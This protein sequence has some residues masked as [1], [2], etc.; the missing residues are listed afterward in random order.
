MQV[1]GAGG[2]GVTGSLLRAVCHEALV[3]RM[4]VRDL[5]RLAVVAAGRSWRQSSL[6]I[7]GVGGSSLDKVG[8]AQDYRMGRAR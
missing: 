8:S 3:D 1:Y 4:E 5:H 7:G 6:R 2:S